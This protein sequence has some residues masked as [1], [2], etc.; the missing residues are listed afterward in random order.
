MGWFRVWYRRLAA[1]HN[2]RLQNHYGQDHLGH[3]QIKHTELANRD[4]LTGL[5]NARFFDLE[6][7]RQLALARAA[8]AGLAVVYCDLDDFKLINDSHGH[9]VGD[10]VLN[11]IGKR[12]QS[13]TKHGVDTAARIGG[14][15]FAVILVNCAE[16]DTTMYQDKQRKSARQGLEALAAS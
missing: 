7:K 3:F 16:A 14:D 8:A 15:E 11:A 6:L 9:A 5:A 10:G 1:F 12:L 4:A 13:L 2:G